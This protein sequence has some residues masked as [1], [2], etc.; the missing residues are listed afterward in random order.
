MLARV[1]F[2]LALPFALNLAACSSDSEGDASLPSDAGTDEADAM[3]EGT[4]PESGTDGGLDAL[5]DTSDDTATDGTSDGDVGPVEDNN[6]QMSLFAGKV[7]FVVPNDAWQDALSFVPLSTWTSQVPDEY[8]QCQ[9]PYRGATGVCAYPMLSYH[10]ESAD[11]FDADAILF[12]LEQYEADKVVV[13]AGA[14]SELLNH[15]GTFT[16]EVESLSPADILGYWKGSLSVVYVEDDYPLALSA[17]VYASLLN[18][19]LVV[20]GGV[21]D[22]SSSFEGKTVFVVGNGLACPASAADCEVFDSLTSLEDEL[23]D[24][25]GTEKLLVVN[26]DDLSIQHDGSSSSIYCTNPFSH[27]F[28]AQSLVAPALAAA[29]HELLLATHETAYENVD[30]FI[31]S[32][33]AALATPPSFL[34]LVASP[35]AIQM[36]QLDLQNAVGEYQEVDSSVYGDITGNEYPELAVGR[37][38]AVTTSGASAAIARSLFYDRLPRSENVAML[39]PNYFVQQRGQGEAN[40]RLFSSAGYT[41]QSIYFGNGI[42]SLDY[43][44]DLEDKAFINYLD[45]GLPSGWEGITGLGLSTNDVRMHSPIVVSDACLTC[46]YDAANA[47]GKNQL[48]C[49][50][51]LRHGAVAHFGA[52]D[53]VWNFD[54]GSMS[55]VLAD[56]ILRGLPMGQALRDF[57]QGAIT[58]HRA[59]SNTSSPTWTHERWHV[60]LGDPTF[61]LEDAYPSLSAVTAVQ[62]DSAARTFTLS[63]PELSEVIESDL[64][65]NGTL[66]AGGT[67]QSYVP[68]LGH[69]VMDHAVAWIPPTGSQPPCSVSQSVWYHV[70]LEKDYD[71]SDI[72]S[73]ALLIN[74]SEVALSFNS[75]TPTTT[76]VYRP[77]MGVAL[78]D[79]VTVQGGVFVVMD[80]TNHVN[81]VM[82]R[83]V[84]LFDTPCTTSLGSVLPVHSYRI[85]FAN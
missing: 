45:H 68:P 50:R 67:L 61:A 39:W 54:S 31:E 51:A 30:A 6:K 15:L 70:E 78:N 11:T 28:G 35:D 1:S 77:F 76:D 60:L 19:P 22:T 5:A 14:P 41:Q 71:I 79:D 81:H 48:F 59:Q 57:K 75:I 38:F 16:G 73:G 18:A 29:K 7:A 2:F 46:G 56:R 74:G 37:V 9:K 64:L 69:Q 8:S 42:T 40:D 27:A 36:S 44:R 84:L 47:S 66:A 72:E 85:T 13:L 80:D 43:D 3:D 82:V 24:K 12:F 65:P 49:A 63:V 26:P 23:A 83:E 10:K 32:K 25:M 17:S 20:E 53:T 33:V 55:L 62:H 4:T 21:L 52:T 58:R 34:T